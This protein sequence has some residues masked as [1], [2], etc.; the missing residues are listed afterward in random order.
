MAAH[1]SCR[2]KRNTSHAETKKMVSVKMGITADDNHGK[3][4]TPLSGLNYSFT[5]AHTALAFSSYDTESHSG[6]S[7]NN[8]TGRIER[9]KSTFRRLF[10]VFARCWCLATEKRHTEQGCYKLHCENGILLAFYDSHNKE[11]GEKM[12]LQ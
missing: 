3:A 1:T 2:K 10:S 5:F 8:T 12:W 11:K 9:Y 6:N 7:N 4:R